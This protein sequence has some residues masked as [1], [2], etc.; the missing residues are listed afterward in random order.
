MDRKDKVG[1]GGP[2]R[3]HLFSETQDLG[4]GEDRPR[5]LAGRR[6]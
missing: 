4:W 3:M 6:E 2:K 5:K 1:G